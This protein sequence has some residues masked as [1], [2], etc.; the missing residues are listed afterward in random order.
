MNWQH[1]FIPVL[2]GPLFS[3]VHAPVPYIIGVLATCSKPDELP[4][5]VRYDNNIDIAS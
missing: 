2:P 1:I 3:Y 5:D 4:V